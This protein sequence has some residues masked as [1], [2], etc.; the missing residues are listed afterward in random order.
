MDV[1]ILGLLAVIVALSLKALYPH[2]IRWD[3]EEAA[4]RDER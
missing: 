1:L 4:R 2:P 3:G